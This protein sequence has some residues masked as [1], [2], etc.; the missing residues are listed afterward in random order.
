MFGKKRK[1]KETA[2]PVKG[3]ANVLSDKRIPVPTPESIIDENGKPVLGTF[4]KEFRN[5]NLTD[6][7]NQSILPDF[8]NK[9]R[10]TLWEACE[11]NLDDDIAILLAFSK[12]GGVLGLCLTLVYDKKEK[13]KYA[14]MSPAS[15]NMS[16]TLLDGDTTKGK[17]PLNR[18]TM[19]ND[20]GNGKA[21]VYSR[22]RGPGGKMELDFELTRWSVPSV[23][24]IPMDAHKTLY[25][26]KDLFTVDG[27]LSWKGKKYLATEASMAIIDDHRGYYPFDSHYDWVTTMG[28]G[29]VNGEKR[30]FGFNLT[31]N[32]S[33]DQ[34]NYNEN[35]LWL[36]GTSSRITPV[37][38]EHITYDLWRITDDYG[39]VDLT[40]D[41]GDRNLLKF[42]LG[43]VKAD[44]SI[45]F[46]VLK[47]YVCDEDGTKYVVDGMCGI[48]E[49]KS[50]R[51]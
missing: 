10:V 27:Y 5:L 19:V 36:D 22:G 3:F 20:F 37:K 24:S 1:R 34:D 13:K 8:T 12:L 31:R 30:K 2:A 50:L 43:I 33:V 6:I 40:Y 28:Y 49:D 17:G 48:G 35:L 11:I 38:F 9:N 45:T 51:I 26:Q 39:M 29:L 23:V 16:Q 32:Q 15:G 21:R 41:I 46:G 7:H 18:V 47:G 4:D 14:Y 44:Y 42:N 25:S